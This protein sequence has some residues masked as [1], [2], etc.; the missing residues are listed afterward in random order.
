MSDELPKKAGMSMVEFLCMML[1][2]ILAAVLLIG[3]FTSRSSAR[4][5]SCAGNLKQIGLIC[6]M[7]SNESNSEVYPPMQLKDCNDQALAWSKTLDVASL[8]PDY[9]TDIEFILSCP[10]NNYFDWDNPSDESPLN[11]DF[12]RD[13]PYLNNGVADPCEM[14]EN[15]YTYYSH[16]L[17][18]H[19][20]TEVITH[21]SLTLFRNDFSKLIATRVPENPSVLLGDIQVS[22]EIILFQKGAD[23]RQELY[24]FY[25]EHGYH[26]FRK[27][28]PPI[29]TEEEKMN[30]IE[31]F[32]KQHEE[33]TKT[34]IPFARI[35]E[36]V[37]RFFIYEIGNPASSAMAQSNVVLM[38]D[39][40]PKDPNLF[41]KGNGV[42]VLFMD[43]HVEFIKN[44]ESG[45]F[46][47]GEVGEIVQRRW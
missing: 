5:A 19:G 39:R 22:P 27:T 42:N 30:N 20:E 10:S 7:Y 13:H 26:Y 8:T 28:P 47:F 17:I 2:V 33:Y 23:H 32:K 14:M 12:P 11:P 29:L 41:H 34:P 6:K 16:V 4:R 24:D 18:Y 44:D 31:E 36:G 21:E 38:H 9:S 45:Q 35:R 1:F 25:I 46:I 3:L 40:I 43:G 15:S 37:E